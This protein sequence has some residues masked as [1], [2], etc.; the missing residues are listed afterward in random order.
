MIILIILLSFFWF[1][2]RTFR[3]LVHISIF[4]QFFVSDQKFLFSNAQFRFYLRTSTAV[5]KFITL[6]IF[7]G[8]LVFLIFF[9]KRMT[10]IWWV[11][12]FERLVICIMRRNYQLCLLVKS[13]GFFGFLNITVFQFLSL[14]CNLNLIYYK[15]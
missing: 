13:I 2:I 9:T 11:W 1:L 12:N 8:Y 4:L 15:I 10:S 5:L 7:S 3:F 14:K 6:L